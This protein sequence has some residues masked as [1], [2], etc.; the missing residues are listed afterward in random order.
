MLSDDI[1]ASAIECHQSLEDRSPYEEFLGATEEQERNMEISI[2]LK[3]SNTLLESDIQNCSLRKGA[4][5]G[6]TRCRLHSC[7]NVCHPMGLIVSCPVQ[8][9]V[10]SYWVLH[11]LTNTLSFF[12]GHTCSIWKFPGQGSNRSCSCQPTPQPQPRQHW[13]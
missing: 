9:C 10:G 5:G 3:K 4:G 1:G 12:H 7:Q 8:P 13:I 11:T 6:L 2:H